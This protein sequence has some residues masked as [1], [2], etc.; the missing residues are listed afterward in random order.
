M[1][2]LLP[3]GGYGRL[4]LPVLVAGAVLIGA[5]S[6]TAGPA[7]STTS[8]FP[9]SGLNPCTGEAFTGTGTLHLLLSDNAS[10]SGHVQFHLE[11]GLSG[12]Q[13]VTVT[14]K[15]YVVVDEEDQVLTFDSDGAP[16]HET[17]EFTLHF[18]RSGEGGILFP[19]DDFLWHVLLHVT[20]NA[21]GT[22]TAEDSDFDL[23]RCQ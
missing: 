5:T 7:S 11:A 20:A 16:V 18:V 21:N 9:F 22:V 4:V 1:A 14:Q 12:L 17:F 3:F 15:K 13:A 19:D 8:P 6:A 2:R 10:N 23:P